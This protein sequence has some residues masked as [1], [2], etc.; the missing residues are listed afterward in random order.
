VDSISGKGPILRTAIL[1]LDGWGYNYYRVENQLRADDLLIRAKICA[2]LGAARAHLK[3]LENAYRRT[4]L[5]APTRE[6]PLPDKAALEQARRLERCGTLIEEVSTA[7]LSAATPTNDAIW[8]RHR[9]EKGLLE[10][11]QAIDVRLTDAAIA[12]HDLIVEWGADAAANP[13]VEVQIAEGLAPLRVI[14]RERA[15]RLTL[16]I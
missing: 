3:A 15:E 14:V 4:Y 5:P 12:L 1:L 2:I 16:M 8:R 10:T 9:E 6:N 13:A 11:L 7:I